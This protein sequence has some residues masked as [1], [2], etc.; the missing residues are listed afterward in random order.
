MTT[1]RLQPTFLLAALAACSGHEPFLSL[2]LDDAL[3][4]AGA[5]QKVVFA[6]FTA[7]WCGPCHRMAE[8][9]FADAGVRAWLREHAI[10]IRIDIDAHKG[11]AKEFD[12]SSVPA[13]V[14]LRPDRTVLGSIVGYRDA[15][16]FLVEAERRLQGVT[17]VDEA[18]QALAAEPGDL[19]RQFKLFSALVTA[20]KREEAMVAADGYWNASRTDMSQAGVRLSFFLM[21]VGRLAH[22]YAPAGELMQR[23]LREARERVDGKGQGTLP[24]VMEICSLAKQLG[25][26]DVILDL[27]DHSKSRMVLATIAT[28][29]GDL[30]IEKRHYQPLVD[31]GT[32]SVKAVRSQ[33][34]VWNMIGKQAAVLGA[35][36]GDLPSGGRANPALRAFEALA[37]VGN[38]DAAREVAAL[39]LGGSDDRAIRDQLAKAAERAGSPALA[40]DFAGSRR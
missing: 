17:A 5:E 35:R 34:A 13:G 29:A 11:L 27:A 4:R 12:I 1:T 6:D 22:D 14:F 9:T 8:T 26:E 24:S 10:P 16:E 38:L 18:K 39:V 33:L 15:A 37:G 31:S 23:W 19:N 21:E 20:G 25:Q 40:S 36:E 2:N 32:C 3:A 28:T 30:L 7:S